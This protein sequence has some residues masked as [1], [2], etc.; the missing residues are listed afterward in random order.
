[1][2][3][4]Y[5][6][7]SQIEFKGSVCFNIFL[8]F[9]SGSLSVGGKTNTEARQRRN[10]IFTEEK[11]RQ[12]ENVGRIEKIEVRY[13]GLPEDVTLM[14]NKGISTPFNCA[15][16]NISLLKLLILIHI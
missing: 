6:S 13:K 5:K 16:R 9:I 11:K 14:M 3:E 15:Q 2:S 8:H 1:M 12:K 4:I 10:L 7:D